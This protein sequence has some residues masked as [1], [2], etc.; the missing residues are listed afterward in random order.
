[1]QSQT[2]I[3][4]ILCDPRFQLFFFFVTKKETKKSCALVP[5]PIII[6]TAE[7]DLFRH[8][9]ISKSPACDTAGRQACVAPLYSVLLL[10]HD[11]KY[12]A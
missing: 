9:F 10:R 1:M 3:S 6:Y 2:R 8:L 4:C 11:K 12:L 5:R 7:A